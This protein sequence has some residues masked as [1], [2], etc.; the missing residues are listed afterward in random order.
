MLKT[1]I[2]KPYA[3][4]ETLIP[5]FVNAA[6]NSRMNLYIQMYGSGTFHHTYF[7][8]C[9]CHC[10]ICTELRESESWTSTARVKTFV[11]GKGKSVASAGELRRLPK[12][13][14]D[15]PPAEL[16][17]CCS[18]ERAIYFIYLLFCSTFK[19]HFNGL[20]FES[21]AQFMNCCFCSFFQKT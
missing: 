14:R 10:Q 4:R 15:A 18:D 20:K 13:T 6:K 2:W 17:Y 7:K 5:K 11:G 3:W 1:A 19:I 21:A 12:I 16:W 9:Q 8:S